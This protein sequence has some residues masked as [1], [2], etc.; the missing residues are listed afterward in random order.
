MGL[1]KGFNTIAKCRICGSGDLTEVFD[2]GLQ[3]LANSLKETPND[4]EDK[5]PLSIS[6]CPD[7]SLLQLN[8]TIDKEVLFDHYVWVTGT[9]AIARSY[10]N[11]FAERIIEILGLENEDFIVE[12]ASNDGTFLKPFIE[13]GFRKVLGVDPAR[14]VAENAN[15]RGIR[16]VPEFWSSALANEL[17]AEF[18]NAKVV[19][20]RNVIP[21]VSELL[22]VIAAIE[23][24]LREDGV[25]VIEF[26]DAGKIQR[27]LHYD[28]IY[29]EHL[30]YFSIESMTHLLKRFELNPFHI[31]ESH[32]SGGSWVIFFSKKVREKS[33][34]L[35]QAVR[36]EDDCN[37]NHL[38]AWQDF[39]RRAAGHRQKTLEIFDSLKGKKVVGFGSSARSQTYL[40]YCEVEPSHMSAIIDNSPLKQGLFTPGS[41]IPIVNLE[42][43][44]GLKPELI[45]VLAWNFRDEIVKECLSAGYDR[46]FL[47]PFPNE[48]YFFRGK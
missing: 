47:V 30:C 32:I 38:S 1:T 15:K 10:A 8:E 11:V 19:I 46:E 4:K 36:I 7:S 40:N 39:A 45:F 26:H 13:K 31:E 21:H 35:D 20:A 29:H 24:M 44:L 5:F 27:D 42:T 16:T 12:I 33:A 25:G 34:E 17:I 22:D 6:Y 14:N 9:S 18:G 2:L 43:G 48:P 41:S 28:S 23:L 37:V 3:P